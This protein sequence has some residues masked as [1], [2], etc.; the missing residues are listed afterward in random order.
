MN[1]ENV[2][3]VNMLTNRQP[4]LLTFAPMVLST[5]IVLNTNYDKYPPIHCLAINVYNI[6]CNTHPSCTYVH[7]NQTFIPNMNTL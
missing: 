2:Y 3:N 4:E 6:K 7:I 1:N 5:Q